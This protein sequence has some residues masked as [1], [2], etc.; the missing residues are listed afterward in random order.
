MSLLKDGTCT[1]SIPFTV[2]K[3]CSEILTPFRG[4]QSSAHATGL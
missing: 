3:V 1:V 2:E 4:T